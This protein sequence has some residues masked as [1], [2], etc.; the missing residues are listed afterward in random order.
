MTNEKTFISEAR[1]EQ[2]LQATIDVLNDIGYVKLSLA[3]IAKMAKISTGLISYHFTDKEELIDHT[4]GY[5]MHTQLQFI[6]QRMEGQT[7]SCQQLLTYLKAC[8]A[9]QREHYRN[10]VALIEIIFNAR[11]ADNIP[12]YKLGEEEEDPLYQRLERVL[13]EGQQKQV[14]SSDFHPKTA[15]IIIN[16]AISESM[17]MQNENVDLQNYEQELIKMVM[18]IVMES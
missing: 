10:N 11:T 5:L 8:L 14:F 17:L 1:R 16:G 6:N 12:F 7:D 3:K 15:A 4:L 2:I 18:K 13:L 9:Y